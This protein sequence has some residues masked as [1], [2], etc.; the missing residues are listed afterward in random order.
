MKEVGREGLIKDI[1]E[2]HYGNCRIQSFWSSA[3]TRIS[4]PSAALIFFLRFV[5]SEFPNFMDTK[6]LNTGVTL[7][8]CFPAIFCHDCH[9]VK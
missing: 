8:T 1:I 5:Y 9:Y 7:E 3:Y 6:H 2:L 4:L